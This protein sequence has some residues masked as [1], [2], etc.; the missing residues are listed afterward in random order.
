MFGLMVIQQKVSGVE[1]RLAEMDARLAAIEH[2]LADI[3]QRSQPAS[4]VD[5]Q[6]R[7]R[8]AI[9]ESLEDS[10]RSG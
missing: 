9:L 6:G 10:V 2:R 5:E 4:G 1:G 7:H 8:E 3:G